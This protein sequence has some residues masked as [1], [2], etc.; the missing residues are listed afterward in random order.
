MQPVSEYLMEIVRPLLNYPDSLTVEQTV[1]D[2]GVLLSMKVH[3]GDMGTLIGKN[4]ETAKSIRQLVRIVG[5][6]AKQRVSIRINEPD[7]SAYK[8]K[9]DKYE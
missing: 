4:G 7:G 3:K 2:M 9:E 5:L 6:I 1:D 8:R